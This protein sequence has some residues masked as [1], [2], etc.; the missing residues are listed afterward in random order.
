[1]P[2]RISSQKLHLLLLA[3]G[4]LYLA[5][6][7]F[8][9]ALWFD[10]SYT[11]GLIRQNVPDLCRIAVYDVHPHLY[12]LLL[13][14]FTWIA[15]DGIV[16]LRLF[17]VA[18]GAV[19]AALGYTHIRRDF[20]PSV[21][22]W[23]TFLAFFLPAMLKYALQIRMYTWAPVFVTLAAI[24][25]WRSAIQE[26]SGRKNLLWMIVFSLASAYTHYFGLLA[27]ACL[28]LFLLVHNRWEKRPLRRWLIPA[29][30]QLAAYL[31]GFLILLFQV[32]LDGASWIRVE[33]PG[34]LA[35]TLSFFLIGDTPED[36]VG[37]SDGGRMALTV[38]S[39]C[40][41]GLLLLSLLRLRKRD[42][43]KARPPLLAA[44]LC[45]SVIGLGLVVSI[46]RPVYYVRY[47]MILY[48]L[49]VFAF[50]WMAARLSQR[51]LRI[52]VILGV[53]ALAAIRAI[54]LYQVNYD[55]SSSAVEDALDGRMQAGDLFLLEDITC[56]FIAVKY[57]DVELYYYNQYGWNV[58]TTYQ[59]F[60][61]NAHVADSLEEIR[62]ALAHHT[63]NIWVQGDTLLSLTATL[64]G[65]REVE[66]IAIETAYYEYSF[67]LVLFEKK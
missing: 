59:A 48:G 13:K 7:A 52:L 53:L 22:I 20:G 46:F 2:K 38:L 31:P 14:L 49:A 4:T 67:S 65:V 18:G 51:W 24:Y 58:E 16:E 63:G 61:H 37:I 66:T 34:V 60:G 56:A 32:S 57:P 45:A 29:V 21:G 8:H 11:V 23:F 28:N 27:M 36:A 9:T 35:D 1:M 12:Y 62:E 15:G 26:G 30:L 19:L 25:A 64:D 55:P 10:E 40:L 5:S 3:A 41:W 47:T 39:V 33:Y 42:K 17:S 44:G 54:P 6:G 50:A 43:A